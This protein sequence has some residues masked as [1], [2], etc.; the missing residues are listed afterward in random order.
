MGN[1]KQVLWD[2]LWIEGT[3]RST[4]E[5]TEQFFS[6]ISRCANTTKYQLPESKFR[7]LL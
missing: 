7:I 2:G 4:G 5:E 6:Y 3:G 1:I